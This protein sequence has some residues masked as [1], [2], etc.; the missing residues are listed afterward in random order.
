MKS[1]QRLFALQVSFFALTVVYTTQLLG[2]Y[3]QTQALEAAAMRSRYE[4]SAVKA[5]RLQRA[6]RT[7]VPVVH[8]PVEN[9][10]SAKARVH[11]RTSTR[12]P[13][14]GE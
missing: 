6:T 12:L 4:Q 7:N 5:D 1:A 8:A 10:I 3:R 9:R 2:L 14:S 13:G 11:A